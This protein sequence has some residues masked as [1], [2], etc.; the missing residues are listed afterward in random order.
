MARHFINGVS[1]C[2]VVV[3]PPSLFISPC[4][5]VELRCVFKAFRLLLV[6]SLLPSSTPTSRLTAHSP[7]FVLLSNCGLELSLMLSQGTTINNSWSLSDRFQ[8]FLRRKDQKYSYQ[9]SWK[10]TN[11]FDYQCFLWFW[12]LFLVPV[13]EVELFISWYFLC[14][15]GG[16]SR[17]RLGIARICTTNKESWPP[18]V[19]LSGYLKLYIV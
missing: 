11:V 14:R 2:P 13:H 15:I 19:R 17:S 7:P 6:L 9:T 5:R 4:S 8:F 1:V 16:P 10:Q 18:D 3:C 12:Q